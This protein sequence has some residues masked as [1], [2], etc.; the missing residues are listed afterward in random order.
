MENSKS[1]LYFTK[2]NDRNI[3]REHIEFKENDKGKGIGSVNTEEYTSL[4][5]KSECYNGIKGKICTSIAKI[6]KEE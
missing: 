5:Q 4:S 1:Q 2:Q 3:N 6:E